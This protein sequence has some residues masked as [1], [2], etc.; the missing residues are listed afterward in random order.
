MDTE[1]RITAV[2][3]HEFHVVLTADGE[4]VESEIFI[5]PEVLDELG[6][7]G[8]DEEQVARHTA[9]FLVERQPVIDVPPMVDLDAVVASFDD[10]ADWLRRA[11]GVGQPD[12]EHG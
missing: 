7:D 9:A 12:V 6:I 2:G 10:Y 1:L 11:L 5:Y 3:D 8:A 4:T